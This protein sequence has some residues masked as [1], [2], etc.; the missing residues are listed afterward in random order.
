MG[1]FIVNRNKAWSNSKEQVATDALL[2][3]LALDCTFRGVLFQ[4]R[5]HNKR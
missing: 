1:L 2:K 3:D 5:L 4:A